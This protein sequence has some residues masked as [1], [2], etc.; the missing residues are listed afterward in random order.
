M[1]RGGCCRKVEIALQTCFAHL[2]E[3]WILGPLEVW[4]DNRAL[5]LGGPKQRALLALLL[6]NGNEVVSRDRL[7]DSLWGE[8]APDSAQR[9]LDTYVSRLRTLLGAGRIERRPPGYLLRVD[10]G[11]LDLERFEALLEQGRAAAASGNPAT[12]R[13]RFRDA[14]GLWRGRPLADLEPE[15]VIGVEAERL[16]ERRLFALEGRIDAELALGGGPE[17]IGELERLVTEHPF[18]QRLLGQLMLSLYRSGRPAEA[19]AAYQ[20][21]RRRFSEELGLEP[22]AELRTLER[23]I[24]EQDAT[25]EPAAAASA[26]ASQRR[27]TRARMLAGAVVV[28]AVVTSAVVGVE[29]GTGGSNAVTTGLA[30]TGIVELTGKTAA[31]SGASLAAAPAAM[32]EGAGSIWMAVPDAGTVVRVDR[33]TRQVTDTIP[34]GGSPS[35]LAIGGGS[36]WVASVPGDTIDRIDPATERITQRI[37]LGDGRVD[38]LAFGLGR[39]W[40]ADSSE[41]TLLALDAATGRRLQAIPIDVRPSALAIGAGGVWMTDYQ[42]GVVTGVDSH[43]GASIGTIPV[44]EG[45]VALAVGDGAIWVANSLDGTVSKVDPVSGKVGTTIAVGN[46][47]VALALSGASVWVADDYSASVSRIDIRRATVARTVPVGGGPTALVAAAGRVWVGTRA[48]DAHRGGT[49]VLLHTRPL[50]MDTAEQ[51][52]LP[53]NQS[54]GLTNDA[55]LAVSRVG[56]TG[57]FVPDLALGVPVPADGGTS[58]TFKLRPGIRYSD[59]RLVRPEDFRRAIERLFR[60]KAG[61]SGNYTSIVGTTSCTV[62]RCDLSRGIVVDDAARTITFHLRSPQADFLG[63]MTSIGTA[64]VPASVP[65]HYTGFAPIPGTGPYKVASANSHQ[66]RYVRNPWFHEWSHAAQPDGN[67]DVIIMR[68]GLSQAQEVREVEQGKADWT[69]DSVP[70]TLMPEVTTRFPSQWHSLVTPDTEWLQ[71]NTTIAPFDDIRV[72]Q[73][74]NL[75]IDRGALVRMYGGPAGAS[76]TCQMVPPGV[77]GHRPYCPWTRGPSADGR[78]HA[79]DLAHAQQLVA[80]SGTRGDRITVWGLEDGGVTGTTALRYTTQV[81]GELGYRAQLRIHPLGYYIKA[82]L[83]TWHRIQIASNSGSDT[84]PITFFAHFGCPTPYGNGHDWYCDPRLDQQVQRAI[85][86][87]GTNKTAARL[88]AAKVDREIVDRALAVPLVNL[89]LFDFFSA[90]VHGYVANPIVGL[91]AD[92]V[93]LR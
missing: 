61:W 56:L 3:F 27:I 13:D 48:L 89:H 84:T 68:Y 60:V 20:A 55:L 29:L 26:V 2:V 21:F 93:S 83:A 91:I 51:T 52:D 54:D 33:G 23:R 31:A 42:G 85:A 57:Q 53:P 18:H 25:L 35:A 59:G 17:L 40:V 45:P 8:R 24:L 71:L 39:L 6:L 92:Q 49:L 66:V 10:A 75:A 38:A 79:P 41:Q 80:A 34:V 72:R 14:L 4:T 87:Y 90:R 64:P 44:G 16:E 5:P 15:G 36:V 9:S 1:V 46:T 7:I 22:S 70:G 43:S 47:P 63:G 62:S 50:W 12:A 30:R 28:A 32:A 74:L 81:L 65:F 11:E 76:P 78:W 77:F 86:L 73:A 82:P 88:L 69:A 37:S 19:L 58:Y 67:P